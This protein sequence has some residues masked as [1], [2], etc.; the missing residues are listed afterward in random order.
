MKVFLVEWDA[1]A[2]KRHAQVLRA[3]GHEVETES[4]DGSR[5]YERIRSDPPD[6]VAISLTRWP[7]NGRETA[8]SLREAPSTRD[9][10]IVFFGGDEEDREFVERVVSGA[11]FAAPENL[12]EA[13]S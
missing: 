8:K 6:A 9:L 13:L 11:T 3:N 7:I 12:A 4:E 10:R 5:A 1:A 2:A